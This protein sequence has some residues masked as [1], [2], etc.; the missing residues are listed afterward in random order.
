M[1]GPGPDDTA[2]DARTP[3]DRPSHATRIARLVLHR[4]DPHRPDARA[5]ARRLTV[6]RLAAGGTA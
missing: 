6:A 3:E 1:P 5:G 2:L 4:R